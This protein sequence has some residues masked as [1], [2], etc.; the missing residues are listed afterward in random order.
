MNGTGAF[1]LILVAATVVAPLNA[2]ERCEYTRE[3]AQTVDA[4]AAQRMQLAARAGS[5]RVTGQAGATAVHVTGT[6]CASSAALLDQLQIAAERRGET[7]YVETETPSRMGRNGYAQIHLVVEIP[8]SLSVAVADGSGSLEIA[9][10][11]ADVVVDDGSGEIT[12]RN[13]VGA[14]RIGDGSGEIAAE[15]VRGSVTIDEDG[16]GGIDIRDITGPVLIREDGSGGIDVR[17]VSSDFTLERDGSGRVD[18]REIG[19]VVSVARRR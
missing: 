14:V 4:A 13:I 9:D 1:A 15:Q 2:Q 3:L 5:L 10:L 6:A 19:G 11:L 8:Q 12:I 18:Y 16:S 17:R 7:V